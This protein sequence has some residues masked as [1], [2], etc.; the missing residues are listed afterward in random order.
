M[1]QARDWHGKAAQQ[2]LAVRQYEQWITAYNGMTWTAVEV[3]LSNGEKSWLET[4]REEQNSALET[5]REQLEEEQYTEAIGVMAGIRLLFAS[6]EGDEEGV[7][8][9]RKKPR[10][11]EGTKFSLRSIV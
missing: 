7:L 8:E 1:K 3:Y 4:A 5:C 10:L 11:P 6:L 2:A 9:G